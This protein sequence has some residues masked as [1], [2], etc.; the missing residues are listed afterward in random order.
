MNLALN[1]KVKSYPVLLF[2]LPV[3]SM[4][5]ILIRQPGNAAPALLFSIIIILFLVGKDSLYQK[6][7]RIALYSIASLFMIFL[8]DYW[9]AIFGNSYFLGAKSD[10]WQYDE[11]WSEGYQDA[12]GLSPL[13][14]YEHLSILHNSV[15]YVYVVVLLRAGAECV[16]EYS[17]LLPRLLNIAFL[18]SISILC[19]KIVYHYTQDSRLRRNTLWVVCLLPVMI[20]NSSHV[21]RDTI[22]CWFF[23]STFYLIEVKGIKLKSLFLALLC[24]VCCFYFRLGSALLIFMMSSGLIFSNRFKKFSKLQQIV[25]LAL[26]AGFGLAAFVLFGSSVLG[27]VSSYDELNQ[28]RFGTIGGQIFGLPKIIGLVPRM[29]YLI[30][31]PVPQLSSFHQFFQSIQAVLQIVFFP[32]LAKA[33]LDKRFPLN[34]KGVF[35]VI[36]LAIALSTA[37]FRHVMMYLPFGAMVVIM[38][39]DKNSFVINREYIMIQIGLITAFILSLALAFIL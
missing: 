28:S 10:D 26:I 3:L 21:F 6:L 11:F 23:V 38:Y 24:I 19:S 34:L 12:F 35:L 8:H 9:I 1:S 27:S 22:V 17:T 30:F 31:T 15:G 36:F 2:V 25:S 14:L 18:V 37:T 13:Y 7:D 16:G 33:M 32:F 20:F 5:V 39:F 4:C 29:I